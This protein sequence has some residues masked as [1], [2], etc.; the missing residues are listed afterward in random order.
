[1]L[2]TSVKNI[3]LFKI[4]LLALIPY[5]IFLFWV[6]RNSTF[7]EDE[8][9]HSLLG[10]FYLDLFKY[11]LSHPNFS[12]I[13]NYATSYLVYYPKLSIYYP[14]LTHLVISLFFA[15][16]GKTY[17]ISR[18]VLLLFSIGLIILNFKFVKF[19]FDEKTAFLSSLILMS[20]PI[21][22]YSAAGAYLNASTNLF[23]LLSIFLYILAFKSKRNSSYILA[24]LSSALGFFTKSV[25]IIP[26]Y[27]ILFFYLLFED[28]SQIKKFILS[29]IFTL[30]LILPYVIVMLKL[31]MLLTIFTSE[32]GMMAYT[33]ISPQFYTLEGWT[34]YAKIFNEHYFVFPFSLLLLICLFL[35]FKNR[36]KH[37]K[38]LFIWIAVIYIIF[39]LAYGKILTYPM[40]IIFPFCIVISKTII[41]YSKTIGKKIFVL[42]ALLMI[43]NVLNISNTI[44]FRENYSKDVAEFVKSNP[45]PV[46]LAT[47]NT[48]IFSSNIAFYLV[49]NDLFVKILRP[50]AVQ[51]NVNQT[52][53]DS[54]VKWVIWDNT[55]LNNTVFKEIK[56]NNLI[57]LNK[58]IGKMEIYSY[59]F[60]NENLKENCNY[61]C[62]TEEKIC[63]KM[64]LDKI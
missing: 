28:R 50:C 33:T 39:S 32:H 22:I 45:Q 51:K 40:A 64:K 60:F 25:F 61:V 52:L 34:Y 55:D 42:L 29:S 20:L 8:G 35:F 37:W 19:L 15:V 58:T 47:E 2:K 13:Y 30:L 7:L 43:F 3:S 16:F 12:N 23:F 24:G 4:L 49:S 56:E 59:N 63:A 44:P 14:P 18:L 57:Q 62:L 11:A 31:N 27:P 54:G 5:L 53:F 48:R 26:I 17:I 21:F 10:I 6:I 38:L 36:E 1:M 9:T 41:Y 46:Y